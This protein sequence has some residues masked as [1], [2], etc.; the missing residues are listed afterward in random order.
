MHAPFISIPMS[1]IIGACK[2][3]GCGNYYNTPAVQG[4]KNTG[5]ELVVNY[6]AAYQWNTSSKKWT[7]V[8]DSSFNT[9]GSRPAFDCAK[10]N[11][12]LSQSQAWMQPQPGGSAAWTWG[13]YPAGVRG[14]GPPGMLFVLSVEKVWNIAWYMLNQVGTGTLFFL[15]FLLFYS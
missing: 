3:S 15:I 8:T 9:D 10:P 7:L 5:S 13:Y 6:V 4:Q 12:G 11:G 14:V 1:L 2:G